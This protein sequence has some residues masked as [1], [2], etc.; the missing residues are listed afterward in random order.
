MFPL[1][2]NLAT[3]DTWT[4]DDISRRQGDMLTLLSSILG[5]S[6]PWSGIKNLAAE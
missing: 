2:A 4:E 5:I 3:F 1:T 6:L